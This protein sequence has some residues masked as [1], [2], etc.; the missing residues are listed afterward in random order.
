M[1]TAKK[2]AVTAMVTH[3]AHD[4]LKQA[5]LEIRKNENK[6]MSITRLISEILESKFGPPPIARADQVASEQTLQA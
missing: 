2:R 3:A 1:G 4:A 6:D 5:V